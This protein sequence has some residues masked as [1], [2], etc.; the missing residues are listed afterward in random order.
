MLWVGA[1]WTGH[2]KAL[3]KTFDGAIVLDISQTKV[4]YASRARGHVSQVPLQPNVECAFRFGKHQ[5]PKA[6]TAEAASILP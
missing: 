6:G 2:V 4:R 1:E 3:E 5:E